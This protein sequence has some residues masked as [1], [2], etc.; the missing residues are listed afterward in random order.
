M[1]PFLSFDGTTPRTQCQRLSIA[2]I[3]FISPLGHA[4]TLFAMRLV[5]R[6]PLLRD[7]LMPLAFCDE[8]DAITIFFFDVIFAALSYA[9]CR[10]RSPRC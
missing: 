8:I 10:R 1:P 7:F 2:A 5:I 6:Q 3:L 4:P 9:D